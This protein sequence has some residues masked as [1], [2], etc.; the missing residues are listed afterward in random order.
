MMMMRSKEVPS[1][2]QKALAQQS[3]A[4][5]GEEEGDDESLG[6]LNEIGFLRE[7]ERERWGWRRKPGS[8]AHASQ[9]FLSSSSRRANNKPLSYSLQATPIF[10]RVL[11]K[12]QKRPP[13]SLLSNV[14]V[15]LRR[16]YQL[17]RG[18]M[19]FGCNELC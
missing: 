12:V 18:A 1:R 16:E 7:R 6:H 13:P 5:T 11:S 8:R 4:A 17:S 3:Q 9:V 2:L 10:M 14:K 15:Q 19:L